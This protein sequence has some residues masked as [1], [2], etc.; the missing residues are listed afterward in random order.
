MSLCVKRIMIK[1]L[2]LL[3]LADFGVLCFNGSRIWH[4]E[5]TALG[6]FLL[7]VTNLLPILPQL[8]KGNHNDR[9]TSAELRD[10]AQGAVLRS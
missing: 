2:I 3:I 5:E 8:K 1:C 7:T 10:Y 9:K 6:R 4:K